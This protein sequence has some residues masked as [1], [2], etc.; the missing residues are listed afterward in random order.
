V[1]EARANAISSNGKYMIS[2]KLNTKI[3]YEKGT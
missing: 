3:R 1:R 2:A